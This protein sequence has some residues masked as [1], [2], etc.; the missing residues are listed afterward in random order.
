MQ[1][2]NNKWKMS[3]S[4]VTSGVSIRCFP[5]Q[6]H[7]HSSVM[8]PPLPVR[9]LDH[10]AQGKLTLPAPLPPQVWECDPGLSEVVHSLR[11]Q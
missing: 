8:K 4:S 5:V 10:V 9:A 7:P 1:K 11:P 3:K 6:N 2:M